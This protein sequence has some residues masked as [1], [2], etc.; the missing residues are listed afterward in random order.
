MYFKMIR[1]CLDDIETVW[2]KLDNGEELSKE[3]EDILR[4]FENRLAEA[5]AFEWENSTVIANNILSITN[6]YIMRKPFED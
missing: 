3:D 4:Y 1:K 2:Q 6:G 5:I